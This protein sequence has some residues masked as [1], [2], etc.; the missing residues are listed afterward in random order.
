VSFVLDI[1]GNGTKA[2]FVFFEVVSTE[3]KRRSA[4]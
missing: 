4:L 3:L 1:N 2:N